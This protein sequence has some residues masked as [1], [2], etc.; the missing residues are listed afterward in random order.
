MDTPPGRDDAT[1]AV[2]DPE[3]ERAARL[4]ALRSL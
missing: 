4:A 3:A 2:R 1:D